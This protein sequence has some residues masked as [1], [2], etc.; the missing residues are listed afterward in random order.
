[1]K[2]VLWWVLLSTNS[3]RT[4]FL[5]LLYDISDVWRYIAWLILFLK[6]RTCVTSSS[7]LCYVLCKTK[8]EAFVIKCKVVFGILLYITTAVYYHQYI[9][10]STPLCT[11]V[12]AFFV[13]YF[14]YIVMKG[15]RSCLHFSCAQ[16][17]QILFF[18]WFVCLKL[19]TRIT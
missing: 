15:F 11:N 2:I 17:V 1:M 6:M 18:L 7:N 10:V 19:I 13:K 3:C 12:H 16:L 8:L 9:F 14:P 4:T 5:K